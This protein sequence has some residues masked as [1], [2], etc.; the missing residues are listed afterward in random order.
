MNRIIL[1]G[2]IVRDP[3]ARSTTSGMA[4][5]KYTIAVDRRRKKEGEADADFFN[6]VTFDKSA[7][8]AAKHFVKGMRVLVS[9]HVQT[10]SYTNKDGQK[11]PTWD[12]MIEEQEFADG[13]AQK[14]AEAARKPAEARQES[15]MDIPADVEDDALPWA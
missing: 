8:F 9:G 7:E 10:G 3:D 6:C 2:R 13:K 15:F 14:P 1:C 4:I 12:V 5:T 11:V